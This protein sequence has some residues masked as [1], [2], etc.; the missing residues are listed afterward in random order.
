LAFDR[1]GV[2]GTAA[3]SGMSAWAAFAM[4]AAA[5]IRIRRFMAAS[6]W[7]AAL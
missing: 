6:A 5:A 4:K 3:G 2:F 1:A 7:T